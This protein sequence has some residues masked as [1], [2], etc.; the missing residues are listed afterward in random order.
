MVALVTLFE[1]LKRIPLLLRRKSNKLVRSRWLDIGL[2]PIFY[3]FMDLDTVTVHKHT[4]N[5]TNSQYLDLTLDQYHLP[6]TH[7]SIRVYCTEMLGL[8]GPESDGDFFSA[9]STISSFVFYFSSK[10]MCIEEKLYKIT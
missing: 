6:F 4:Q 3:V 7:V 2:I 1:V 8:A 5:R 9:T 10:P